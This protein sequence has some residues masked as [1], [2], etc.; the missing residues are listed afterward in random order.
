MEVEL[1]SPHCRHTGT[2]LVVEDEP[3]QRMMIVDL[4][5]E[6]GFDVVEAMDSDDAVRILKTRLNIRIVYTDIDMPGGFDG[7]K[8]AASIR[9]SWPP[10]ELIREEAMAFVD[11]TLSYAGWG[12][13]HLFE[14][15]DA[16]STLLASRAF[17]GG[18]W[19]VPE[20]E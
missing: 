11:R 10:I 4:V 6:A 12:A 8:L 13:A 1:A 15:L 3:I 14:I 7:M 5:E 17:A 20:A 19:T 2:V 16:G 9:N 18:E